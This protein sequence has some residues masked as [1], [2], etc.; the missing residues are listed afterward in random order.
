VRSGFRLAS[1][2]PEP[3]TPP[4]VLSADTDQILAELG[5]DQEAIRMLKHNGAV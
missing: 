2:G 5:Y 4:P 1:G 3:T